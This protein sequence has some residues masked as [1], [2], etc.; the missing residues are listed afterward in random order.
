MSPVMSRKE[1]GA[2]KG[3]SSPPPANTFCPQTLTDLRKLGRYQNEGKLDAYFR[4]IA[5]AEHELEMSIVG[6]LRYVGDKANLKAHQS[7]GVIE[8]YTPAGWIELAR[9]V[10]G[11][12]DLDPASCAPVTAL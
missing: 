9:S 12:I 3:K 6:F 8:W 2:H 5:G 1:A 7:Q 4:V 11:S 10:M